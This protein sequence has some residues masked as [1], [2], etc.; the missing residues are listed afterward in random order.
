MS[1]SYQGRDYRLVMFDLDDTL[2]P[3]KSPLA[4]N[5]VALLRRMLGDTLGC[6][7]SGGRF[8]Q[9]QSQVLD[10]LGVFE[11]MGNLHLMPTCGTQ[12]VR[13]SG[14]AW[15]T[16]YAEYLSDDEKKRTLDVLETGARELGLWESQTW[17]P[18]LEDRGS[19]ITF[20]ALGQSA[21][22]DAKSAWDPDGAKKESLRAYAAQRLPD[23]EIRSGGSTSVD[24]TKKGIDK[25]YGANKLMHILDLGIDDILFFG[26]RLDEGGNDYP[27]KALGI[28]SIAVHGWEDTF[29][30][31]SEIV[32]N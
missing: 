31:L 10:R 28:T 15:E 17:G 1:V 8:G 22:V 19:Q 3:S 16:V 11:T 5:M 30:K 9:F 32:D 27:V 29:A 25:A 23:L 14:E 21:P 4:D 24:V 26:D 2:A 20:S 12:Y 13:W 6:I 7:I 18:I